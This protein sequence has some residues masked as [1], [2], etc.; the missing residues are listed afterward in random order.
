MVTHL[1]VDLTCPGVLERENSA[2]S[3]INLPC[4]TLRWSACSDSKTAE[5]IV[6]NFD[7]CEFCWCMAKCYSSVSKSDKNKGHFELEFGWRVAKCYSSVSKSDKN[8]GHFELE[9]FVDAWRSIS[10]LF[11]IREKWSRF[12]MKKYTHCCTHFRSVFLRSRDT[13][14]CPSIVQVHPLSSILLRFYGGVEI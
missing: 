7:I 13:L 12:W 11:P 1:A 6:M 10:A 9:S 4:G 2:D 5:R 14:C 3:S 8:K